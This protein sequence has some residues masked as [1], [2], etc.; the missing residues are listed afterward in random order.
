VRPGTATYD[1]IAVAVGSALSRTLRLRVEEI[2]PETDL[3]SIGLDSMAMIHVNIA[4]EEKYGVAVAAY[5]APESGI[6]T[7][8]DL[9][10]FA[11]G[12]IGAAAVKEAHA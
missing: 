11:A 2:H 5:D 7:V 1:E 6:R 9:V 3:E 12:Q 8:A 4:L 10:A